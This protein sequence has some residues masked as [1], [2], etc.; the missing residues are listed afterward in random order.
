MQPKENIIQMNFNRLKDVHLNGKTAIV[1]VDFNLPKDDNGSISDDTRLRAALPTINFLTTANAKVILISHLGRPNGKCDPRLSLSFVIPALSKALGTKVSF[2]DNLEFKNVDKIR[3]GEIM[4][5]ENIRF[6]KGETSGNIK[7]ARKI[8]Q[9]GDVFIQDAFSTAHR[10]HSSSSVVGDLLPSYPGLA[11]ER[12]IE[13]ISHALNTPR[14]PVM[15][16]VGGAK[17]STKI[18]LLGNLVKKLDILAIGG[19]MAN[20]FLS[21]LGNEVGSSLYEP[22]FEKTALG[23]L[24]KADQE[25]CKIILPSDVIVAKQFQANANFRQCKPNEVLSDEMILDCG[26]SSINY[27]KAALDE[28]KTVIWNGP[29]GAFEIDPFDKATSETATYAAKLTKEGKIVS[30]AGGGD[31]VAALKNASA[32]DDFTFISTAGGAF[33]EWLEGKALPGI[34]ILKKVS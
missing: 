7:L 25:H 19:G 31:T 24:K 3:P 12:E 22:S 10:K 23:I 15:G 32:A 17:V 13:H 28:A 8:A 14:S 27:I 11:M 29:L 26:E 1:R 2:N 5:L 6:H 4:L 30:V 9:L 16:V 34:E 18:E 33:L 20:T 21:A